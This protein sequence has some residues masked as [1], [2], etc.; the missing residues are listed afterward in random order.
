M[1]TLSLSVSIQLSVPI[2]HCVYLSFRMARMV[3]QLIKSNLMSC[4]KQSNFCAP[5][6]CAGCRCFSIIEELLS[7][8]VVLRSSALSKVTPNSEKAKF[9]WRRSCTTISRNGVI[10][11]RMHWVLIQMFASL[12]LQVTLQFF[13]VLFG[14]DAL[15]CRD[16]CGQS[17]ARQVLF[18]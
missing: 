2:M 5:S 15:P 18:V 10:F 6:H 4:C 12:M 7:D 17:F 16:I 11:F 8:P 1:L 14:T 3:R 9:L 13:T